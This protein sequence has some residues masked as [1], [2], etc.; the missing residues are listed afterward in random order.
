MLDLDSGQWA[1][2]LREGL[3]AQ[4]ANLPGGG[5]VACFKAGPFRVAYPDFLIGAAGVLDADALAQ[6]VAAAAGMRADLIRLQSMQAPADARIQAVHAVGSIAIERLGDWDE[7]AWE[8]ARRAGNRA[9]RS[10]LSLRPGRAEDG[11]TM[12]RLYQ[13][14][15]RRH[16]GSIR[17]TRRYFELIAPHAAIVAELD[18]KVCGFVCVGFQGRRACY[19]HGAHDPE[20]RAHYPS[21]QLFLGML[22]R[23]RDAGME[24]FDFLPSPTGQASLSVYK[25]AWGGSDEALTVSDLA[26]RPLRARGFALAL[27]L[28]KAVD[29]L[30]RD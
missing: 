17:Y 6:R 20:A 8:K 5:A 16:G 29:S 2:A 11:A 28:S 1:Q 7:R 3:G 15:L 19:M 13:A 18:G 25:R 9:P 26:L 21:D 14:T 10:A 23:A 24:R 22:R 12:D 4:F 27:R 30:R